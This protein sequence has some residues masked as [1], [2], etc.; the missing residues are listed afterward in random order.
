MAIID[1]KEG[2]KPFICNKCGSLILKINDDEEALLERF[3]KEDMVNETIRFTYAEKE[4]G[5]SWGLATRNR[6]IEL[7]NKYRN[8]LFNGIINKD[9]SVNEE[10][11]NVS[12]QSGNLL[13]YNY[14]IEVPYA[15]TLNKG[16][17]ESL[18]I[19]F[20]KEENID[21][22]ICHGTLIESEDYINTVKCK[23]YFE[24]DD[25]Y[26]VANNF[27]NFYDMYS[28]EK[29]DESFSHQEVNAKDLLFNLIHVNKHIQVLEEEVKVLMKKQR[30]V[31]RLLQRT[32]SLFRKNV[33]EWVIKLTDLDDNQE[34]DNFLDEHQ[35]TKV[36]LK[37]C[38]VAPIAPK[39]PERPVLPE[40]L[41]LEKVS[42]FNKKKII[43]KNQQLLKDYN[44][45]KLQ[46]AD[47]LTEYEIS[48]REYESAKKVYEEQMVQYNIQKEAFD[49]KYSEYARQ[50]SELITAKIDGLMKLLTVEAELNKEQLEEVMEKYEIPVEYKMDYYQVKEQFDFYQ[51]TIEEMKEKLIELYKT[52]NDLLSLDVIYP[53][54]SDLISLTTMYEYFVTGRVNTLTGVAGAYRLYES[55]SGDKTINTKW[56]DIVN[57]LDKIKENQFLL[58]NVI[59]DIRNAWVSFHLTDEEINQEVVVKFNEAKEEYYNKLMAD[60]TSANTFLSALA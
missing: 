49:L 38:P 27:N 60:C 29:S 24:K 17:I 12:Y 19:K 48:L 9:F 51:N 5:D 25:A 58:Y 31:G 46:Y 37:D 30:P 15:F 33:E 3:K 57:E 6:R 28:K 36:S 53:K 16:K 22:P 21:C 20:I 32:I 7:E 43:E 13:L 39:V 34:K 2:N 40:E 50:V 52:R 54:Y 26:I 44:T 55:E 8:L 47:A 42:F 10:Q 4:P 23:N 1:L 45:K 41:V 11:L 18:S 56:D 35:I 14:N 59:C